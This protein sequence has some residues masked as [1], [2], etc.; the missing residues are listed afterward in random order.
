MR[1]IGTLKDIIEW[2][3][4]IGCGACYYYCN[5]DAVYLKNFENIGIRP[6][7]KDKIC[8]RC[9][10]CLSIC[11]GYFVNAK[12]NNNYSSKSRDINLMIGPTLGIFQGYANEMKIRY[13]SSS[14]GILSALALYCLEK[15]NMGFVLH[16]GMDSS[17][18]WLNKTVKSVSRADILKND[19]SRYTPSSPC[20]GLDLIE[21]AEK[22]CVFIGKPCDVAAV[23]ALRRKRHKLDTN[24]GIVMSLFCAGTPSSSGTMELLKR[25]KVDKQLV[26]AIIYRGNGW[27]GSFKVIYRD[28]RLTINSTTR[29]SYKESWS[30]LQRYR[31][32]RCHL[33]PD[34]LGE[35]SDI[36]CGDAWNR[37]SGKDSLGYSIILARTSRGLKLIC[38][39]A[40]DGYVT[41]IPSNSKE[42]VDSQ[43]I[44]KRR[45]AIFGRLVA[46]RLLVIPTPRFEG[47]SLLRIWQ[48]NSFFEKMQSILGTF[49]R[50]VKHRLYFRNKLLQ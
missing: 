2:N 41:L 28:R 6:V 15:K 29:L 24:L 35:L 47:F 26:R 16:T 32:F 5:K 20:E 13:R 22:P 4:C 48:R 25:L 34:G 21:K 42:V 44:V 10:E 49:K 12:L 19:G 46:M 9:N 45:F 31:P 50:L 43:N 1:S 18:P 40:A 38:D 11:P 27:P 37:P 7:I 39:A 30:V 8:L 23:S 33:C 3:L 14:G 17:K 36:T